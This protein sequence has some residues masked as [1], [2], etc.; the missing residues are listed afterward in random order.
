MRPNALYFPYISVPSTQWTV[1]SILYWDKV[2]SIVP[3]E[4]MREP[5]GL[6][7]LSRQLLQEGL[8]VPVIPAAHIPQ[9][10]SFEAPFLAHVAAVSYTHLTLP[11]NRE[12]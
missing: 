2:C 5:E 7:E 11:T 8:L 4:Q 1:Q 6:N 3:M 12:V 9:R 10:D